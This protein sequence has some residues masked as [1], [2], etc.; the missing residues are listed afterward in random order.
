MRYDVLRRFAL[1]DGGTAP[2][3]NAIIAY[4]FERAKEDQTYR[5]KKEGYFGNLRDF[6]FKIIQK[7][8]K[9]FRDEDGKE[10]FKA[11]A[12]LD[13]AVD[14]LMQSGKLDR[15]LLLT[16]DGDFVRLVRALQDQ[17]CR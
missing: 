11:N 10:Y 2:R 9:R 1:R 8:V 6:G 7:P 4:D 3:L 5:E 13:M 12:D 14:V 15:V 17:G 16:G